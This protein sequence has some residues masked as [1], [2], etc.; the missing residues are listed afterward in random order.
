MSTLDSPRSPDM[1]T[2]DSGE[3]I[4]QL[5]SLLRGEISAAETYRMAIDKVSATLALG[6]DDAAKLLSEARDA[7]NAAPTEVPATLKDKKKAEF[8]RN[9]LALAYAKALTSRKV[10]E[11]AL[12]TFAVVK[13]EDVV[14]PAAF[15][16][17]KAVCEYEL[18][19]KD[20][21]DSSI[22]R[23][24]VDVTDANGKVTTWGFEGGGPSSLER[25]GIRPS[26]LAAGTKLKI[27]GRPMKNGDPRAIWVDAV[28][29]DGKYFNPNEGFQV[30]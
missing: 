18:M 8:Y 28:R 3:S 21:A 20:R 13:P 2:G 26:D 16:F 14:D 22:D 1:G 4:R 5:N 15:F 19:L 24:L 27:T 12:E 6:D 7:D 30:K 25:A 11:E 10:Y 23:L 9:N 29:P 17:H